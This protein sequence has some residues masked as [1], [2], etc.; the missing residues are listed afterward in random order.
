MRFVTL[1]LLSSAIA[2]V[3]AHFPPR[4]PFNAANE[5]NFC[6]N[7][8]GLLSLQVL[9]FAADSYVNA[10]PNRTEFP[11]SSGILTLHSGHPNWNRASKPRSF[12]AFLRSTNVNQLL[13]IVQDPTSFDNFTNSSGQQQIVRNFASASAAGNYCIPLDLSNTGI[14]G[15]ADGANVTIQLVYNAGDGSLYDVKLN[16][17]SPSGVRT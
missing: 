11:L 10:V 2:V 16:L 17:L 7:V 4:G 3:N 12:S 14:S 1:A 6:G 8:V 9:K 5:V 15:V 13:S